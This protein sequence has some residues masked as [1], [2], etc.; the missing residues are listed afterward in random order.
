[1]DQLVRHPVEAP[2]GWKL[3][4]A[5]EPLIAAKSRANRLPFAMLLLFFRAHGRFPRAQQEIDP[6]TVADVARQIG[7]RPIWGHYTKVF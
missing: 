4:P 6:D 1:M 7:T 5:D 3:T 2:D